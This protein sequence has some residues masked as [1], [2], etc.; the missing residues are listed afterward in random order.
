M[1]LAATVLPAYAAK[2][3]TLE[4]LEQMLAAPKTHVD[5]DLGWTIADLQLTE[6]MDAATLARLSGGLPG[7]A[8]R[9]ALRMLAAE[10][11]FATPTGPMVVQ[12][13][14]PTVAEQREMMGRVV[15]YVRDALPRLPNLQA[16]RITNLYEDTPQV[17][18][19][20]NMIPYKPMHAIGTMDQTL[21][22]R[23]GKEVA[24]E[25]LVQGKKSKPVGRQGMQSWGLFGPVL[26]TVLV[27]A[28][29]SRLE[30]R[31][32]EA[33]A[34]GTMAVF[35][36]DVPM[37]NSHYEV[38]YCCTAQESSTAVATPKLFRKQA[39]YQGEMA[40][41]PATGSILRIEVEAKLSASDPIVQ[42]D[43]LVEYGPVEIGGK[44]YMC[45]LRSM[46][47]SRAR[48]VL[49]NIKYHYALANQPQWTKNS[50]NVATFSE[51]HVFRSEMR[52]LADTEQSAPENTAR[53]TS[54]GMNNGA[55]T[56]K[57]AEQTAGQAATAADA[58]T[59]A[60][61]TEVAEA[62][63]EPD[64]PEVHAV[65]SVAIPEG[66]SLDHGAGEASSGFTLRTTSRLV[67]V[68]LVAFDKKG[69]P[70]TDLKANE[71][72]VYDN[73]RLEKVQF[74]SQGA[75]G[76]AAGAG[77]AG[78][79]TEAPTYS[80][81]APSAPQAAPK[82]AQSPSSTVILF[83]P[84][85][86]A[87]ADL[88][89]ARSE[90]LRFLG[91]LAADERVGLYV[92]HPHRF[93]VL[94]EPTTDHAAVVEKLKNW[95]PDAQDISVGSE[96]EQR[97]RQHIDFVKRMTDLAFVNGNASMAGDANTTPESLKYPVDVQLRQTGGNPEQEGMA[98]LPSVARHLGTVPGHKTL[99]WV[100]GDAMLADWSGQ[101]A[102]P[103]DK[104]MKYLNAAAAAAREAL[105][106]A[107][108]SVYPLDA[109]QLEGGG[110]D[111]DIG[112]RNV[113]ALGKSDRDPSLAAIGDAAPGQ[114]N[115]RDTARM[116][117]DVKAI[118]GEFR[119]LAE[120]T[121][122]RALRRA[123]D[124]ATE[125]NGIV[126]DGRAAYL[127][128]FA[129]D[130]PA[131]GTYH[132][133][134]VKAPS[135]PDLVLRYRTG[136]EYDKEPATMAE[137]VRA[138]VWRAADESAIGLSVQLDGAQLKLHVAAT[139]LGLVQQ[140]KRWVGKLHVFE[141]LRDDTEA[142]A[143]VKG[144]SIELALKPAT[145]QTALKDGLEFDVAAPKATTAGAL[146]V[147]VLDE[148]TGRIGTVTIPVSGKP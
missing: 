16:R 70:V 86:M 103:E 120:A 138:A 112:T 39:A 116:Q 56:P 46:S 49:E 11:Q 19:P 52:I 146:R 36:F 55:Q 63:P 32:W 130:T 40:I 104:G 107:H 137:R 57:N 44:A 106:E 98:L 33:G 134:A 118:Q 65:A 101:A 132:Q 109:S 24:T 147:V 96:A 35:G 136:Y 121:G 61:T 38:D 50:L 4:Q 100:T 3:V 8:S 89:Y 10:S 105:N 97:N 85:R 42:A 84:A 111:A 68:A 126:A 71:V 133:I 13:A 45:P 115:G 74:F 23:D 143:M 83:D 12:K 76:E 59:A 119:E 80:N 17:L 7:E 114:K 60:G 47:R 29:R 93:E 79:A 117:Q 90:T 144:Q 108:V 67:D 64:L 81:D 21:V 22:Y 75:A 124:I 69:K 5:A 92:M 129:P 141:A 82:A 28:A 1:V 113:L 123:S 15:G 37:A 139:D 99:V 14:A 77:A 78:G 18:Q 122:G 102:A 26:S 140:D 27:D 91:T 127:I 72:E 128:G 48:T 110:I 87:F 58:G 6:R 30:W 125:L 73:G 88:G 54:S 145:Y 148:T 62:D 135:R 20:E 34:A 43:L 142:R 131:D 2:Q 51:Y 31:R 66:S 53:G 9:E 25:E 94:L 41:D 95:T